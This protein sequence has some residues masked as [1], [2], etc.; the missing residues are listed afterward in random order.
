[1]KLYLVVREAVLTA[2]LRAAVRVIRAIAPTLSLS[3]A[4]RR[5]LVERIEAAFTV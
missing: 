2:A 1:M 4:E 3:A 5:V